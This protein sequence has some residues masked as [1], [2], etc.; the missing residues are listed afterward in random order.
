M[1][2]D[3]VKQEVKTYRETCGSHPPYL[4][5]IEESERSTKIL[6]RLQSVCM[7]QTGPKKKVVHKEGH[8][9]HLRVPLG[10]I[11]TTNLKSLP[12]R[13]ITQHKKKKRDFYTFNDHM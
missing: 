3:M 5:L 11:V 7:R 9:F 13:D 10:L 8:P 2:F 1:F 4:N 6:F 12:C